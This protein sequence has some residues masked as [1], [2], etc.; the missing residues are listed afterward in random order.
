[1]TFPGTFPR[2]VLR[3]R[4]LKPFLDPKT[5]PKTFPRPFS[6]RFYSPFPIDTLLGPSL[7]P[8]SPS[9]PQPPGP[10]SADGRA[11]G[12]AAPPRGRHSAQHRAQP[13][14]SGPETGEG[15]QNSEHIST[16]RVVEQCSNRAYDPIN[17]LLS[18]RGIHWCGHTLDSSTI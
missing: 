1:M 14:H 13:P 3:T 5:F 8:S 16:S 10:A 15:D 4:F 9:S 7:V 11:H 2:A 18:E 6:R 17:D 12:D